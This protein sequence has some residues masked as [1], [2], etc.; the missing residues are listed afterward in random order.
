[1]ASRQEFAVGLD[2]CAA[3]GLKQGFTTWLSWG[4]AFQLK[5]RV[6]YKLSYCRYAPFKSGVPGNAVLLHILKD[7]WPLRQMPV[8][9]LAYGF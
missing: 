3:A 7:S 5:G 1:M 9:P 8:R 2:D 6:K 4:C